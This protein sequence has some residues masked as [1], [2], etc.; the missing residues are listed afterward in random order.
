MSSNNRY[1][2]RL[3]DSQREYVLRWV[4]TVLGFS[5][6][7]CLTEETIASIF[8]ELSRTEE[9]VN[10]ARD[11]RGNWDWQ[12]GAAQRKGLTYVPYLDQLVQAAVPQHKSR[13]SDPPLWPNNKRFALI[14]THDVDSVS[15]LRMSLRGL[16]QLAKCVGSKPD[17]VHRKL[18]SFGSMSARFIAQLFRTRQRDPLWHYEDWLKLE[19]QYG[20]KSTFYFFASPIKTPAPWDCIY[21]FSDVV[22]FD[23]KRMTVREMMRNIQEAGWEIGLH[24]SYHSAMDGETLKSEKVLIEDALGSAVSSIRQHYLHYDIRVT[25]RLHAQAGFRIDSTQGFN[26][27]V[28]FRAGTS[29]PYWCWDHVD[30]QPLQVLEIPQ[31]VQD[32]GLFSAGAL[33]YDEETAVRHVLQLMT[34]VEEVG[35]CLTLSW[36]PEH[37]NRVQYWKTYERVL[38]EAAARGAWGC[39]TGELSKWWVN[40]EIRVQTGH[41]SEPNTLYLAQA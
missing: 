21:Q 15:D 25:P 5:C 7:N 36:H 22:R 24:G 1:R 32:L 8:H 41:P 37:C 26:R 27:S 35:G 4:S 34:K 10:P 31:H 14:L 38:A 39:G 23:G 11:W 12:Y 30:E 3:M 40:R 18:L 19:Q 9:T 2:E 16:R 17:G 6:T 33:E 28:G 29:F 13:S 20:F